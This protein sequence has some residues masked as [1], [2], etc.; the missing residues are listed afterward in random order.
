MFPSRSASAALILAAACWGLGTVIAKRAIDEIPPASLLAIQLASSVLVLAVLV[1]PSRAR[2]AGVPP[3]LARLGLLNPGTAYALSLLGLA[4]ITASLSVL[5]WAAEPILILVLAAI[6]LGERLGRPALALSVV[7]LLGMTLV[8]Y[9]PGISG[10]AVGIALT[11]AGVACCAVYTVVSRRQLGA[12]EETAVVVFLQQVH[13]LAFAV[14]LV[15]VAFLLGHHPL[16]PGASPVALAAA[17]GSGV[18]YYGA[19]YVLYLAA[20]KRLPA[21]TAASSFYLIP[22]F[23]VAGGV[24]ALDERLSVLQVVGAGLALVR[25]P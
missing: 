12:V 6:V 22:V 3:L 4:Q 9:E 16:P 19:A 13:A 20:L 2:I 15:V 23:G 25:S 18:L 1:R 8:L 14:V 21:S 24:M 7:A 10:S 11:L 5:L 17:V